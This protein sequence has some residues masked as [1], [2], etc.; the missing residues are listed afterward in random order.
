ML[1]T[2]TPAIEK[3]AVPTNQRRELDSAVHHPNYRRG[4]VAQEMFVPA[5]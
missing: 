1:V 3:S 5:V 2:R 4:P